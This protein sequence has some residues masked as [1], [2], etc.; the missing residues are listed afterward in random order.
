[1]GV[2]V[3]TLLGKRWDRLK[4]RKEKGRLCEIG[5]GALI[6]SYFKLGR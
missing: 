6:V 1:M 3:D 4:S 2:F 5:E